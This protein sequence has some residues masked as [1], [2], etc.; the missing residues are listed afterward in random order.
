MDLDGAMRRHHE[1]CEFEHDLE[2]RS[3]GDK[4]AFQ[5]ICCVG[6]LVGL[7]LKVYGQML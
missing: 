5:C 1:G 7:K 4:K 2:G 3:E 6:S